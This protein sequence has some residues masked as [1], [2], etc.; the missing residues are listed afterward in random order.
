MNMIP[1]KIDLKAKARRDH[2]PLEMDGSVSTP[3]FA[4]PR[5]NRVMV[6]VSKN[7]L[8]PSY[9]NV[10]LDDAPK[11]IRLFEFEPNEISFSNA[12]LIG[13]T[14]KEAHE[15]YHKKDVAYLQS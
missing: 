6:F 12:E 14:I 9:V 15:L 1:P 10:N 4:E 11:G 5:I 13:L 8:K 3:M 2:L 7:I